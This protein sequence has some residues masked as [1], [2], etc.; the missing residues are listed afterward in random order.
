MIE[1]PQEGRKRREVR[2]RWA[3]CAFRG[4]RVAVASLFALVAG[5]TGNA[6]LAGG[7][8]QAAC[9]LAGVR[10]WLFARFPGR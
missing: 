10:P 9:A 7:L 1:S 5:M 4:Q 8:P 6:A 3:A 2:R